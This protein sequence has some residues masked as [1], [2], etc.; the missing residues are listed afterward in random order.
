M[1]K[2]IKVGIHNKFEF[3]KKNAK[4]GEVIGEY[5]AENI[6]LNNFWGVYLSNNS[7]NCLAYVHFGS[8]IIEPTPSDVKLTTWLGYKATGGNTYDYSKYFTEGIIGIKRSIRLQ[9][10]EFVGATIS[11]I[12]YSSSTSGTSGLLTKALVKDMNGNVVSIT[13]GVGDILDIYATFYIKVGVEFNGGEISWGQPELTYLTLLGR[14]TFNSYANNHIGS[15]LDVCYLAG[16]PQLQNPMSHATMDTSYKVSVSGQY[17]V[18]NRKITWSIPNTIA[19]NGNILGGIRGIFLGGLLINLPCIGFAQPVLTKEVIGT[20]DG[21]TRDFESKFGYIKNNGTAKL[22][23]NDVEQVGGFSIDYDK[24]VAR[25]MIASDLVILDYKKMDVD[26][27]PVLGVA[28]GGQ[29]TVNEWEVIAENPWYE[30]IPI[31]HILGQYWR[32]NASNDLINW[33]FAIGGST[34]TEQAVPN[35]YKNYKYWKFT[36]NTNKDLGMIKSIRTTAIS[37]NIHFTEP[38]SDGDVISLSYQP[39]CI[40]KDANH[41]LNNVSVAITFNEYTP[42]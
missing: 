18:L 36:N 2:E 9:D 22:Y 25:T 6:I 21:S 40:A 38:P 15:S 27:N 39:N 26:G 37:K 7:R 5:K 24:F 12:G 4:T 19:S 34:Q 23:I 1:E 16:K 8:G 3:V 31:T 30:T 33:E 17:D 35:E 42:T 10:T 14:L 28:L 13:K 32:A 41:V 11:E 29:A 20:G